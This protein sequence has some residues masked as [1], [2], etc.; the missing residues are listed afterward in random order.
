M[1]LYCYRTI[2]GILKIDQMVISSFIL[3]FWYLFGLFRIAMMQ[4][5]YLLFFFYY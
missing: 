5:L 2:L 1:I 4:E 3:F